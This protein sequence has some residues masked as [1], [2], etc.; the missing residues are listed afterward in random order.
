MT[1]LGA[2]AASQALQWDMRVGLDLVEISQLQYSIRT[3]GDAFTHRLFTRGELDYS[4][5]AADMTAPRL[6]ARFAAKEAL[7]K[8]LQLSEAGVSWRDIEVIKLDGGDCRM[9][10]HGRVAQLG[11]EMGLA[12]LML[13]LSH[14]GDYAGAV[15]SARFSKR[16]NEPC[17]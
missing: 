9:E 12:G 14:D 11:E 3:F 5:G 2:A 16:S 4:L 15:V 13:S 10:L 6:A 17:H 7:I 8:A 1:D